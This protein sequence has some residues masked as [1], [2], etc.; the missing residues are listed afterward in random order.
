MSSGINILSYRIAIKF[1]DEIITCLESIRKRKVIMEVM[2]LR[3][4]VFN[5]N[6]KY[7]MVAREDRSNII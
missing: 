3:N 4:F 5:I 7:E 6:E 2:K 1:N